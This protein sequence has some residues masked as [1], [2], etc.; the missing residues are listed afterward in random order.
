MAKYGVPMWIVAIAALLVASALLAW[1]RSRSPSARLAA[2]LYGSIVT[3]A[4]QPPFFAVIGVPDTKDGR[5]GVLVLHVYLAVERLSAIK[6]PGS[7]L[8][9]ALVEA[10]VTDI[11]DNMREIG[12]GDP[13]VPKKVKQAAAILYER[14]AAYRAALAAGEMNHFSERLGRDMMLAAGSERGDELARYA[15]RAMTELANQSD[16]A[17]LAGDIVFPETV[18]A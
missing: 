2:R 17:L 8:A 18:T 9:R 13:S 14:M 3:A 16:A 5:F 12:I 7:E 11:D 10:F 4:R 6:G 15:L 1:W